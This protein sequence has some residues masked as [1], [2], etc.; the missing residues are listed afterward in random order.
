MSV[1]RCLTPGE[2][3]ANEA[4][5]PW[6][7]AGRLPGRSMNQAQRPARGA[8][9]GG[10]SG[11]AGLCRRAVRHPYA[12]PEPSIAPHHS[13]A[14]IDTYICGRAAAAPRRPAVQDGLPCEAAPRPLGNARGRHD[15][16]S[17]PAPPARCP[18]TG[19]QLGGGGEAGRPTVA[20]R[21]RLQPWPDL[22]FVR[23][24]DVCI[25]CSD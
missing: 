13:V 2:P 5:R 7:G 14:A 17:R 6:L 15:E 22:R 1:I 8:S 11:R 24:A 20:G 19:K 25:Y 12:S 16:R 10:R 18:S 21:V 9:A 4:T 3:A 23:A